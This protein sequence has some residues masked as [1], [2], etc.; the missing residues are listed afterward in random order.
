MDITFLLFGLFVALLV[1]LFVEN[2]PDKN[3]QKK[4][5][6]SSLTESRVATVV[7]T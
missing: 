1:K 6:S 3:A 5:V 7:G 4:A 2:L